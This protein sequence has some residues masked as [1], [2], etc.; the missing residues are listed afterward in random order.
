[1]ENGNSLVT[2]NGKNGI[3]NSLFFDDKVRVWLP[4]D[5][6]KDLELIEKRYPYRNRPVVIRCDSTAEAFITFDFYNKPLSAN[7]VSNA[8]LSLRR[9]IKKVYPYNEEP[10]LKRFKTRQGIQGVSLSFYCMMNHYRQYVEFF[11]LSIHG[12][13]FIGTVNCAEE[14][15]GKWAFVFRKIK[16]S[17]EELE[18]SRNLL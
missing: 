14:N 2:E 15:K 8:A 3:E 13:L 1:M 10:R 17:I 11:I 7:Q 5:F 6:H 4:D 12:Q 18:Q 9:L 16:I